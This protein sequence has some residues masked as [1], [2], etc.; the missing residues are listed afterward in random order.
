M[1]A[2]RVAEAKRQR[3]RP[4]VRREKLVEAATQ[5]FAERGYEGA[6][7][8]QIAEAAD[9]SP[10]L[11][12]RH[13]DGKQE[14]YTEILQ[15]ANRELMAHLTQAAA[16]N[17]PTAERVRRGLDA[18]FT[19]VENHRELWQM[20]MKDVLEPE[21]AV[22]QQEVMTNSVRIIAALAAQDYEAS[23]GVDMPHEVELEGVATVVVGAAIQLSS[24][25]NDHPELPRAM[26]VALAMEVL[27]VGLERARSG[28]RYNASPG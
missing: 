20:L 11:L 19:F 28:E 23:A 2:S 10:G 22:I 5:V 15:T 18:F 7:V 13:F 1:G 8:E 4:E 12:Y 14:V 21:I 3:L 6:R 17:L 27:W 9:V 24:W 26:I 25:W 16:P